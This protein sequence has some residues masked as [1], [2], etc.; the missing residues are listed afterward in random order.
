MSAGGLGP[1]A[2]GPDQAWARLRE[3][4]ARA[5][6]RTAA[7]VSALAAERAV[8]ERERREH[9]SYDEARRERARRGASRADR[10]VG[11]P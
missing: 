2:L 4:A 6:E 8:I 11:P 10:T 7:T 1:A 3:A 5:R 9:P